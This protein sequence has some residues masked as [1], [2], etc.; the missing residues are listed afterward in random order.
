MQ[1]LVIKVGAMYVGAM[2]SHRRSDVRTGENLMKSVINEADIFSGYDS[3]TT[4][5]ERKFTSF[6]PL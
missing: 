5:H 2:E 4:A 3:S 6:Y 1:K